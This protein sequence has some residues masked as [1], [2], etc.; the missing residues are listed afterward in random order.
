MTLRKTSE[1]NEWES[2]HHHRVPE[3]H[4]HTQ[5]ETY[6]RGH[7][8]PHSRMTGCGVS[9][10]RISTKLDSYNDLRLQLSIYTH[11]ATATN[12]WLEAQTPRTRTLFLGHL[13]LT[14]RTHTRTHTRHI[15]IRLYIRFLTFMLTVFYYMK[16]LSCFFPLIFTYVI[17]PQ[18]HTVLR[19]LSN[20]CVNKLR[21]I[22]SAKPPGKYKRQCATQYYV[23]V[24]WTPIRLPGYNRLTSQ[25]SS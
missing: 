8:V 5:T 19:W 22:S 11:S 10:G 25:L 1:R 7:G 4:V 20:V 13:R 15:Q 21:Q 2:P 12:R 6:T 18:V 9:V 23:S 3:P 24:A 17:H 16:H 14:A